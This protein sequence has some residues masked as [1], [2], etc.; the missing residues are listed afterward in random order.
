MPAPTTPNELLIISPNWL[1][2]AVMAMPAIK[3]YKTAN[4]AT[5]IVI[6]AKKSVAPIWQ[7]HDSISET[8]I[9]E[10]G[11]RATFATAFAL[12][13][14]RFSAAIILPNSFRSALIP[15]LARIP[16]RRAA[17]GK[18][19]APLLS[20]IVSLKGL[21]TAHQSLEYARLLLGA[22]APCPAMPCPLHHFP[23][24]SGFH[25]IPVVPGSVSS[26]VPAL[27]AGSAPLPNSTPHSPLQPPPSGAQRRSYRASDIDIDPANATAREDA[28]PPIPDDAQRP[29]I[30]IPGAA[31]G[32]SKRWP[33]FAELAK[34]ILAE[35][36]QTRFLICGAPNETA[37]CHELAQ[38]I[39]ASAQDIS[40]AT[41][42]PEFA[43]QLAAAP[44]VICNDSGG[45]HLASAAGTPVLAIYGLT[46]PIKTGPIGAN[47][48]IVQA[49]GITPARDI[50]RDSPAAAAAMRS[51]VPETVF[52]RLRKHLE[53]KF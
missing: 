2:D 14:R 4:P 26:V 40:G 41:T 53:A 11:N 22:E 31:R 16:I 33:Y 24:G 18:L 47:A 48:L 44:L 36:P 49:T 23:S 5:R 35:R 32:D 52:K 28:R 34:L 7:M 30:L 15:Y 8:I 29:I 38:K 10:R 39:G 13:R 37:L 50:P 3:A 42:L 27:C 45:M 51:I 21:D 1:G 19:R 25:P 9:L 43:R 12:R 46:N 6:L 17:R 20:E